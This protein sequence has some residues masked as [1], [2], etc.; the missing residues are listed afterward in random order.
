MFGKSVLPSLRV[1][2][3]RLLISRDV[4]NIDQYGRRRTSFAV[5]TFEIGT[6][7]TI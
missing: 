1:S 6:T 5:G 3:I 4:A 2:N 7:G